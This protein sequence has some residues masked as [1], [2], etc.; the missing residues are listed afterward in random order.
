MHLEGMEVNHMKFGE[1]KVKELEEKY[2][3]ILFHQGEKKF[4]YPNS[5]KKYLTLKDK[6]VQTEMDDMLKTIMLEEE[7][8]RAEEISE[9]ERMEEIQNLKIRPDS[10][11]VFGFVENDRERVFSSWAVYAGSYQSGGSK[12]KPKLPVRL[13]LNSACLLTECPKGVAEKRRRIIGA[14]MLQDNFE[15][16][17]CRDGMIQSHEKYRIRLEDKEMLLY[18]DYFS[19]GMEI[20]K[21]GNVELKYFSNTIMEKILQDMQKTILDEGRRK[22]AEEFYQYF[23]LINRIKP[24]SQ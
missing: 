20:S 2:I 21:W 17:A 11:A 19:E 18:W 9:Q 13:K 16:S 6:N 23:C 14:F 8:K 22:E 1:G 7:C 15:S 10:Q 24:V 12:G 4:L 5:F 3:T